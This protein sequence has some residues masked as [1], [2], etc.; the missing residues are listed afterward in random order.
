MFF[1]K[2]HFLLIIIFSLVQFIWVFSPVITSFKDITDNGSYITD[3]ESIL[4]L[5][6]GILVDKNENIYI[7]NDYFNKV[8]IYNKDG[9]FLYSI[10][11]DIT[12]SMTISLD[13][14]DNLN[15]AINESKIINV[16]DENGFII[17]QIQDS[18][19]FQYREFDKNLNK[20]VYCDE[21]NYYKFS[22]F[23]GYTKIYKYTDGKK[24][25]I[26]KLETT[27]YI[28]KISFIIIEITLFLSII[29]IIK[30]V[31]RLNKEN[32]KE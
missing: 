2:R 11:P 6:K 15:I 20:V 28:T 12:G 27:D 5:P 8:Q 25:L 23:L 22:N 10:N 26:Y 3:N 1:K 21:N 13:E 19:N 17:N 31:K 16:Y 4:I 30:D 32:K 14:E 7:L 24:E 9:K 18:L 29:Y